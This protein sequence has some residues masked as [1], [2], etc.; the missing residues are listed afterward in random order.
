[1]ANT[2]NI[3]LVKPLGTDKALVSVI[4]DNSDKI[5]AFAGSVNTNMAKTQDGFAIVVNGNNAPKA[6]SAGQYL[7]IKNHSTLSAGGYH[8]TANIAN[9]AAITSS[10]VAADADGVVNGAFSALNDNIFKTVSNGNITQDHTYL[11]FMQEATIS[12]AYFSVLYDPA[13]NNGTQDFGIILSNGTSM[14]VCNATLSYVNGTI[15]VTNA[16]RMNIE[17]TGIDN[18]SVFIRVIRQIA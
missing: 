5:D 15:E 18:W 17:G 16:R 14:F 8:A 13:E 6:I 7:F 4:N 3:N 2:P 12:N 10:N 11:L 1:M 9:G